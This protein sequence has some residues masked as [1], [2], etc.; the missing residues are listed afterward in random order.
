MSGRP[1]A[2]YQQG[3]GGQEPDRPRILGLQLSGHRVHVEPD[4]P[5]FRGCRRFRFVLRD[6]GLITKADQRRLPAI[7]PFIALYVIALMHGAAILLDDGGRIDLR[8][9]PDAEERLVV[10]ASF[11][12]PDMPKPV[13]APICIFYT[14]YHAKDFVSQELL[15]DLEGWAGPLDIDRAGKVAKL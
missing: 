4:V 11:V 13:Y 5:R 14:E 3:T 12:F 7:G 9:A 2:S 8:A 10:R 1:E 6:A 15:D